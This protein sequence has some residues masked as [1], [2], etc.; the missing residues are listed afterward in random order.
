[1]RSGLLG[2][3]IDIISESTPI[4]YGVLIDVLRI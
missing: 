2:E 3:R 1:M 4:P